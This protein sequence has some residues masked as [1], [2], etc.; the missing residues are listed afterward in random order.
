M[1]CNAVL[2]IVPTL[3][4]VVGTKFNSLFLE[5]FEQ[6]RVPHASEELLGAAVRWLSDF[7][8]AVV[9]SDGTNSSDSDR[10]DLVNLDFEIQQ[11]GVRLIVCS[12]CVVSASF[13]G[14]SGIAY[15][16]GS[17]AR[18]TEADMFLWRFDLYQS[19]YPASFAGAAGRDRSVGLTVL[20]NLLTTCAREGRPVHVCWLAFLVDQIQPK[21]T[22]TVEGQLLFWSV[23][24]GL[25]LKR[26]WPQQKF[27]SR[28]FFS[29]FEHASSETRHLITTEPI[30]ISAKF[31]GRK[32]L[33][34]KARL[35]G[36][37]F[38]PQCIHAAGSLSCT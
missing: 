3:W 10:S 38:T 23:G 13:T 15:W 12:I 11:C 33:S 24:L 21:P 8:L 9:V 17:G 27:I 29:R 37:R 28:G 25:D 34:K 2:G 14:F 4:S 30:R 16:A 6:P 18:V 36:S 1:Y 19:R 35:H 31:E 7:L 5:Q 22:D 32:S 20:F 26:A